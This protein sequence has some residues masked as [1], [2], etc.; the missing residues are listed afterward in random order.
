MQLFRHDTGHMKNVKPVDP[1]LTWHLLQNDQEQAAHYV[2]SL[3]KTKTNPQ[4][5]ENYWIPNAENPENPDE[6][7]SI[8]RRIPWEVQALQDLDTLDPTKD[9]EPR[10]KFLENFDGKD[11]TLALD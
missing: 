9:V 11:S 5:S 8:Q 10:S 2:S 3:I 7:T 1:A 4:K 6:H